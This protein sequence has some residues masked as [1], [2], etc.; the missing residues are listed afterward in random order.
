LV[1]RDSS[2]FCGKTTQIWSYQTVISYIIKYR[3]HL[4]KFWIIHCWH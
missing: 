2:P 3:P 4:Y 1:T